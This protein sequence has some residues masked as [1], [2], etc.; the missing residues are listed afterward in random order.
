[1]VI[2]CEH[3][4]R[5]FSF[6]HIGRCLAYRRSGCAVSYQG[7]YANVYQKCIFYAKVLVLVHLHMTALF[8]LLFLV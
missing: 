1:M 2:M 6:V 8:I 4:G 3:F 7:F 5:L